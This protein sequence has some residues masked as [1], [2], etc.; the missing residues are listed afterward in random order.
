MLLRVMIGMQ[1]VYSNGM[2][3]W[4]TAEVNIFLG[5]FRGITWVPRCHFPP[6]CCLLISRMS[7]LEDKKEVSLKEPAYQGFQIFISIAQIN[8][9]INSF[10]VVNKRRYFARGTQHKTLMF[11][12]QM[13]PLQ[14]SILSQTTI[15]KVLCCYVMLFTLDESCLRVGDYMYIHYGGL[16]SNSPMMD[17]EQVYLFSI[18]LNHFILW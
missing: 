5:A 8:D 6:R 18:L 16:F 10:F 14:A 17:E 12:C 11:R 2:V 13:N 4:S 7:K 9:L 1:C 15:T 3:V